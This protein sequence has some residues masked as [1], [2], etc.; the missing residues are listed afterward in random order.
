M[1]LLGAV[2]G[3]YLDAAARVGL[4]AGCLQIQLVH[5]ALP[6]HRIK[7]SVAGELL[8]A[9]EV[10][11]H[12]AIRR[13]FHALHFFVQTHGDAM[14]AQIVGEG[15]HHFGISE[16]KQSRPFFHQNDANT[17]GREHASVFDADHAAAHHDHALR[18]IRHRQHLIAIDDVAAIDGHLGGFGRLGAG[19]DDEEFRAVG[20]FAA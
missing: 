7:Q 1:R 19:G 12:L 6:A 13:F 16:L 20:L 8:L 9:L 2:F 5:V 15:F 10:G 3:V 4:H 11:H 17:Q 14:I 18:N